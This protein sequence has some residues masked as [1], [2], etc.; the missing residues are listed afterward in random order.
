LVAAVLTLGL[1]YL[2]HLLAVGPLV[3]GYLP[4]YLQEE[5]FSD[6]RDRFA[7][8]GLLLPAQPRLLLAVA[9]SVAVAALAAVRTDPWRPELAATWLF[10]AALLISTPA[11]P[12]YALPLVGLAVLAG[13]PEWLAVPVAGY[14]AYA[15]FRVPYLPGT[16]YA[17]AGL[18][19]LAVT[20]HR[21]NSG[22]Y[23]NYLWNTGSR[24]V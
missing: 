5:G 23:S 19:V 4:G 13:R 11:Y 16:A 18:M 22:R 15:G 1:S 20:V 9:L 21:R 2:P 7:V 8:L 12:W 14:V 10:G 6:G 3:A 24:K 17:V